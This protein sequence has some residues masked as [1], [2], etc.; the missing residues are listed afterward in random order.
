[1]TKNFSRHSAIRS[2][3]TFKT[4][5]TVFLFLFLTFSNLTFAQPGFSDDVNDQASPNNDPVPPASIDFAPLLLCSFTFAIGFYFIRKNE[6][7]GAHQK[8]EI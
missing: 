4:L 6:T 5:S 1:M 7:L 8:R 2:C 3:L